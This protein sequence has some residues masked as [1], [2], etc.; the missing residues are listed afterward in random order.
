MKKIDFN[1]YECLN[2]LRLYSD[3][4]EQILLLVEGN[5]PLRS[6][7]EKKAQSIL[8]DL[9][10]RLHSDLKQSSIRAGQKQIG[11][12]EQ[13]FYLPAIFEASKRISV[14]PNST[15]D[16]GWI[17]EIDIAQKHIKYCL[18]QLLSL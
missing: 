1:K 5:L 17:D 15:P 8:K 12:V 7:D 2:R 13:E 4:M 14:D 11:N 18:N 10:K 16:Q 6:T 9:K 3:M